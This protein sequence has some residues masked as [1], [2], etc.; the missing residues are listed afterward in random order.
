MAAASNSSG[1]E[2]AT[3]SESKGFYV[4]PKTDCQH[5]KVLLIQSLIANWTVMVWN[6]SQQ[7]KASKNQ[8]PKLKN[9]F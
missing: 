8:L 9:D 4:T 1:A 3:A 5:V 2:G 7:M 6:T